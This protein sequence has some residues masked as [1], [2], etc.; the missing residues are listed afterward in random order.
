MMKFFLVAFLSMVSLILHAQDR[1]IVDKVVAKVGDEVI[2]LSDVE[3]QFAYEAERR[4]SLPEAAKCGILENIMVQK[5]LVNQAKL[6]SVI[7]EPEQIEQQLASRIDYI[8]GLMNNDLNQFQEYYGKS[9]GA[10][11]N[12]MRQDMREQLTA[13]RMQN[14]VLEKTRIT[15]SEVKEYFGQ[16]PK[17]SLPYF[18]AE[19]EIG[20]IV[21][22]PEVNPV[23]RQKAIDELTGLRDRILAGEDF[24]TLSTQYSDD[25][26]SARKGGDLGLQKRGTFVPEFEAAAYNLEEGELSDIVESPFGFHL[27][28]LIERRGNMVHIRHILI[29]PEITDDDLIKAEKLLDSIRTVYLNDTTS[30]EVTVKRYSN[31]DEQSYNNGG[32]MINPTTGD[33]FFETA[34][35]DADIFFAIDTMEVGEMSRPIPFTKPQGDKAFRVVLLQSRTAPHQANL[36]QD[37]TKVK[38]AAIE[39]RKQG[40]LKKWI[41]DKISKT[42]VEI[43]PS[44]V[45][46]CE[47]IQRW[48]SEKPAPGSTT[49]LD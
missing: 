31:E 4:G 46:K 21:V 18:S 28:E 33:T 40:H 10:M 35:L 49:K 16:I 12:E 5:L 38:N 30:F 41:A 24:A 22:L 3:A 6:D 23:E 37:Y 42:F 26:G 34:E 47:N 36:Q 29:K 48:L 2:L 27:M 32:R 20:E 9:V 17:D 43:D 19:V 1:L 7:V 8:L 14:Q 45:G 25:P 15:P 11:R 13:E 39:E 44:L